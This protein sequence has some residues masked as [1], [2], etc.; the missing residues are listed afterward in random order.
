MKEIKLLITVLKQTGYLIPERMYYNGQTATAT[1]VHVLLVAATKGASL[2]L[3][4]I[5][6]FHI[7]TIKIN[8]FLNVP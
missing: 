6:K 5:Y 2:Y 4:K 7:E 8:A 3:K 1:Q